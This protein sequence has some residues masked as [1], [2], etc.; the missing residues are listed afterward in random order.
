MT[1]IAQSNGGAKK[2]NTAYYIN[3]IIAIVIMI[4][5]FVVPPIAPLTQSGMETVFIFLGV[6]YG[7]SLIHI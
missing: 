7:L 1:E 6:V 4:A 5:G 3:S 2:K